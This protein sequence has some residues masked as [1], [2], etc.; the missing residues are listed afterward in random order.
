MNKQV[1]KDGIELTSILDS[2][3]SGVEIWRPDVR[4]HDASEVEYIVETIRINSSNVVFWS[5]HTRISLIQPKLDFRRFPGDSQSIDIRYGSYAYNQNYIKMNYNGN[6]LSMNTNYDASLTFLSNPTWMWNNASTSFSTYLSGSGFLNSIYHIAVTRKSTG[7]MNRITIPIMFFLLFVGLTYWVNPE[8]RLDICV[9]ILLAVSAL[10]IVVL[11]NI[12]L[13]GYLTTVDSYVFYSFLIILLAAIFHVMFGTLVK[14]IDIW[15]LRILYV[16]LIETS[17]RVFVIPFM[18]LYFSFLIQGMVPITKALMISGA[19]IGAV[20]I[21]IREA[22]G[23]RSAY[24]KSLA[25]LTE[26]ANNKEVKVCD[27]SFLEMFVLNVVHFNKVSFSFMDLSHHLF[28]HKELKHSHKKEQSLHV[29]HL[30]I[31]HINATKGAD[32]IDTEGN[33]NVEVTADHS[34]VN[35]GTGL[36]IDEE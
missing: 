23:V 3:D 8:R 32:G 18:L 31:Y 6:E 36:D 5:R 17:G 21:A 10:Y 4:F 14:K 34:R 15:P 20:V 24:H 25:M 13:V 35:F 22:P 16:R 1:R 30:S 26:K 27:L 12:P 9:G 19:I 33:N 28:H 29:K 7:A 11:E 2:R